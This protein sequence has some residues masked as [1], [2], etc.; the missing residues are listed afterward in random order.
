MITKH[1]LVPTDDPRWRDAEGNP[2]D[3]EDRGLV[4]DVR[5]LVNHVVSGNWWAGELAAGATIESVGDRLDGDV[6]GADATAAYDASAEVAAAAFKAPGA[7]DRPVAVSYGP[8][9]GEVYAGHRFI[10]VLVHGWDLAVG[11]GQ[12]NGSPAA[13]A[14]RSH[15]CG[16]GPA[17]EHGDDGVERGGVRDPQ[18]V[19][20]EVDDPKRRVLD[21]IRRDTA[22]GGVLE[23]LPAELWIAREHEQRGHHDQRDDRRRLCALAAYR[24]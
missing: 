10:D 1:E 20:P 9:P 6:L 15:E 3:L 22:M 7:M 24:P 18:A 2:T 5:T 13:R 16:V 12:P 14:N 21:R 23:E 8:V 17:G 4:F 19:A 11:T